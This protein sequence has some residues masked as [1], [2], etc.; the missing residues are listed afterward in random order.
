MTFGL[1]KNRYMKDVIPGRSTAQVRN[2]DGDFPEGAAEETVAVLHLGAKSNHAMG[3]LAPEFVKM[4]MHLAKIAD[5]LE[6]G[7]R[8]KGCELSPPL[9][10][11]LDRS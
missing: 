2:E 10:L 3:L 4:A 5:N 8:E 1:R 9:G 7:K 6:E 11:L